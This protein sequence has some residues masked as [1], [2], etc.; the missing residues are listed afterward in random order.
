MIRHLVFFRF[1]AEAD[2][3]SAAANI[4]L[5]NERLIALKAT[6]PQI[7]HLETGVDFN[8]SPAAFDLA[9]DTSFQSREDLATYQ[10]HPDHV[11]VKELIMA[12]TSERAVVDYEVK[13]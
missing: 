10:D 7:V 8:R 11:A 2:G 4:A 13:D 12:V 6:I 1:H 3:R 9:L 5:V